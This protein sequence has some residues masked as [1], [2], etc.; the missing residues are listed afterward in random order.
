MDELFT[1]YLW[2]MNLLED[3][4]IDFIEE[5]NNVIT[6]N[7]ITFEF[8]EEGDYIKEVRNNDD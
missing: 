6:I 2:F 7:G 1:N 5:S 8:N 4:N 3:S